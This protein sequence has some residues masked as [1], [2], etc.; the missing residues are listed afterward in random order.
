MK[1][2][3][4]KT[5]IQFYQDNGYLIVENFLSEAS[6]TSL[7]KRTQQIVEDFHPKSLKVFTTEDQ[8]NHTDAYFLES[9]DKVH[10]FFEEE[11]I[12]EQGEMQVEKEVAY[13]NQPWIVYSV[14]CTKSIYFQ[15]S[16]NRSQSKS[17]YRFYFYLYAT[18]VLSRS[19]DRIGRCQCR[20]WLP[21][22]YAWVS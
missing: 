10:C 6:I 2:F 14:H 16:Q 22:G 20:E 15:T 11:A 19:L 7:K 13:S 1:S 18:A 17:T 21:N 3:L 9:G 5:Q 12:S 4:D 8:N